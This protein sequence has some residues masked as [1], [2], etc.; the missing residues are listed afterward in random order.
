MKEAVKEEIEELENFSENEH[1]IERWRP[2]E[3]NINENYEYVPKGKIFNY[4]SLNF[5]TFN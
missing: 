5:I 1:V 2:I 4:F 3:F